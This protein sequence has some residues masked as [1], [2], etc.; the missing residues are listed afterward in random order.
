LTALLLPVFLSLWYKSHSR[1]DQHRY[2]LTLS[3][4]VWVYLGDGVCALYMVSMP[5]KVA[6]RSEFHATLNPRILAKRGRWSF[7][8]T[9]KGAYRFTWLVFPFW[10]P[11]TVLAA[12]CASALWFGPC[13]TWRR[14][15]RGLCLTCGYDIK[16]CEGGRCSECGSAVPKRTVPHRRTSLSR[17]TASTR[18]SS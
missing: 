8:T 5:N 3:K 9:R 12:T 18:T 4:S 10:A 6:S 15:R 17:R 7:D 16:G 14:E 2:D 13:R 11:S 1:P